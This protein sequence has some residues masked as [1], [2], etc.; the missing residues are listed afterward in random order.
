MN[1][2]VMTSV[3]LYASILERNR[4]LSICNTTLQ[5]E[6]QIKKL[7]QNTHTNSSTNTRG[8]LGE[9]RIVSV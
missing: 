5:A 8:T 2:Q 4:T 3:S 1:M 6:D 7:K 9:Q